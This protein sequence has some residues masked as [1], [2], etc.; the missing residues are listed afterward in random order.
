MRG[1]VTRPKLSTVGLPTFWRDT[2][3][4]GLELL[5]DEPVEQRHVLKPATIIMRE[6]IAHHSTA[7]PLVG[8]EPDE[9]RT[10]VGRTHRMLREHPANLIGFVIAGA[11]YAIPN[12]LLPR[13][14]AGHCERH[15]LLQRHAI[16]GIDVVQLRRD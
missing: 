2:L 4:V 16:V 7:G 6:Q 5:G 11:A 12:L 8:F 1:L 3:G 13:V 15:Q 9:L 10:A 14:I